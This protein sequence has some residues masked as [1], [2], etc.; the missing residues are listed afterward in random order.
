[1]E[2]LAQLKR[3]VNIFGAKRRG[4]KMLLKPPI[5]HFSLPSTDHKVRTHLCERSFQDQ[6]ALDIKLI[7]NELFWTNSAGAP[8]GPKIQDY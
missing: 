5:I 1:M 7:G 6:A 4:L 8:W 2:V 3:F